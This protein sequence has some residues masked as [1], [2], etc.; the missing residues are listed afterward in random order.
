MK[1]WFRTRPMKMTRK[2]NYAETWVSKRSPKDTGRSYNVNVRIGKPL[3]ILSLK[4]DVVDGFK[5]HVSHIATTRKKIFRSKQTEN[6]QKCPVCGTMSKKARFLTSIYGGR[7]HQCPTCGHCFVIKRALKNALEKFY[8]NDTEY[9]F[10]YTNNKTRN[11]RIQ[12]ITIPKAKWMVREFKALYGRRPKKILDV[13]AGAGHF[14]YACR[15]L[16]LNAQGI[17]LS[18]PCA[19]YCRK[20]FGIELHMMDFIKNWSSFSDVDI[21]TFWGVIE[22]VS[23]PVGLLQAARKI[24]SKKKGFIVTEVPRWDSLS[25]AVQ[26]V[27]KESVVRHLDPLTHI[28]LFSDDSLATCFEIS[29]F[30]PVAAWYFGMDAYELTMQLFHS[31]K[32]KHILDILKKHTLS[33]QDTIDRSQLSDAIVLAGKPIK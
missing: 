28:N 12:Q 16:G 19:D 17:E 33:L 31:S 10:T 1:T 29:G 24:F 32:K 9:A 13:G 22:H 30:A 5:S 4:S 8:A 23:D 25:T 18:G 7:F 26:R 20:N 15:K 27:F 11:S 6:V 21:V 14:V 2:D 3:D